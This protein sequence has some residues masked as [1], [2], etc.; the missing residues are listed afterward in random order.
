LVVGAHDH[1][2][3]DIALPPGGAISG[4]VT[5]AATGHDVD[6]QFALFDN[7][8]NYITLAFPTRADGEWSVSGLNPF[9][10]YQVCF[11]DAALP[12]RFGATCYQNARWYR[13]YAY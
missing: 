10:T 4:R 6:A 9:H 3:A 13:P 1:V 5:D 2:R 8:G 7:R 11:Q 12:P